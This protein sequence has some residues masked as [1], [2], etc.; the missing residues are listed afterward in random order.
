V[1]LALFSGAAVAAR[2]GVLVPE[3]YDLYHSL[4]ARL[5]EWYLFLRDASLVGISSDPHRDGIIVVS[6]AVAAFSV[7][8]LWQQRWVDCLLLAIALVA[9]LMLPE[10]IRV[11]VVYPYPTLDNGHSF[12]SGHATSSVSVLGFLA[13]LCC[14]QTSDRRLRR[15]VTGVAVL[16]GFIVVLSALTFHYVTDVIGGLALGS[17]LLVLSILTRY[18]LLP[19]TCAG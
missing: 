9:A 15:I 11:V 8:L 3:Q 4:P 2:A 18:R 10:L 12:P 7:L 6:C 17:A 5:G 19:P 13:Y 1:S 16:I 14:A